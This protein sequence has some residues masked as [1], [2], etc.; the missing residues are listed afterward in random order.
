[1]KKLF[2]L[3]SL[4]LCAAAFA[5]PANPALKRRIEGDFPNAGNAPFV[6]YAVPAMSED[7]RLPEAYPAD[8]QAGAPVSIVLARDEYE[9]GSF[10]V[11][12]RRGGTRKNVQLSLGEFRNEKGDVFPAED[13]DLKVVKVWYQNKNAWFSYFGDTGRK[14]VPEL[15][16]HDET[17]F[18]VDEKKGA[19]YARVTTRDD[20]KT[21][22]EWLNPPCEFE[23]RGVLPWTS[24]LRFRSMREGFD[25]AKA[26]QPVLLEECRFKQ[27]FLTAHA[28]KDAKPGLYR[29]VVKVGD[30]GEIPV[31]IR[32]LD[33]ALP[34]PKAYQ[35]PSKDFLVSMYSDISQPIFEE[36]NGH[37]A[38]LARR[39]LVS[40]FKDMAAHNVSVHMIRGNTD[41]VAFDCIDAMREAGLRTDVLMGGAGPGQ[42]DTWEQSQERPSII[43]DELNRRYGHHNIY[44]GCG[45]EPPPSW[46]NGNRPLLALYQDAGIRFFLAASMPIYYLAGY[47]FDWHNAA[48]DASDPTFTKRWNALQNRNRSAWYAVQHV[49][50]ENPAFNRRQNGLTAYLTGYTSL[51]NY[52]FALDSYNDEVPQFRP[53]VYGYGCG[54]GVLDTLQWE[55]FREGVDDIRYATLMTD[56][57]RQA[58]KMQDTR[59]RYAGGQ[60]MQ[61]LATLDV[62]SFDQDW[63]RAEMIRYISEMLPYVSP[64][65]PESEF[66]PVS[67][68]ERA[69]SAKR[70]DERLEKALAKARKGFETA[71]NLQETNKVH[72][73]VADVYKWYARHEQAGE[74]LVQHGLVLDALPCFRYTKQEPRINELL[75]QALTDKSKPGY[76]PWRA[77]WA[78]LE[79]SPK[80]DAKVLATFEKAIFGD[81]KPTDTNGYRRVLGCIFHELG[82]PRR[83]LRNDKFA[84]F[85]SVFEKTRPFARRWNVA[86]PADVAFN[87][88]AAYAAQYD[89]R[90]AVESAKLGLKDEKAKPETLYRL[91]LAIALGSRPRQ[92]QAE[93]LAAIRTC[94]AEYAK[95]LPAKT[96]E[97]V[98]RIVGAFLP[99]EGF[100]DTIRALDEFR[101]SLLK[102]PNAKK[103]Y[104]VKFSDKAIDGVSDWN[105]VAAEETAYDRR[106]GGGLEFLETDVTT[107]NRGAVGTSKKEKMPDPT[108]KVVANRNGIHFFIVVKDPKA[109][110]IASGKMGVGSFEGYIAPG[111]NEPYV[112]LLMEP[113]RG[114][115]DTFNTTYNTFGR[116]WLADDTVARDY[117]IERTVDGENVVTYLF[118]SWREWSQKVPK[119]GSV[120]DFENLFWHRIGSFAWNG[121]ESIHGRS[122]WGELEFRLTDDQRR[123]ILKPLLARAYANFRTEQRCSHKDG[124][125]AHWKDAGVGDPAFYDAELKD[126]EKTL[127]SYGELLKPDISGSTI[128]FLA[129]VALPQWENVAFEVQ[130]RRT[131]WL[132]KLQTK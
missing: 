92:K 70:L 69:A 30:L 43:V 26:L 58:Q 46:F 19:N 98:L 90:H 16:L 82:T 68:A 1:M 23:E 85:T 128:D 18:R 102:A 61:F 127:A 131:R 126:L 106:Y 83:L 89:F 40:V 74:Y 39:Q 79:S 109:K 10:L 17:L 38:K 44:A 31:A 95:G 100:E 75:W 55:G 111:E 80:P 21:H 97:H 4:G 88:F 117:R 115:V 42:W 101:R 51:C 25:D 76:E 34:A 77:F 50:S 125:F 48:A 112:C 118:L 56:L 63:A 54:S 7:P 84:A 104:V 12:T 130:R 62:R 66:K 32:V 67:A 96:R 8:G 108:M 52:T 81:L 114:T 45:D 33:F 78:L 2:I 59:P 60:A 91:Q 57:A 47:L 124:V 22:E 64:S 13:L 110:E 113:D 123:E 94:D 87:A 107:G 73:K 121:T 103:R 93:A 71:K 119:D 99:S 14:L 120:W 132:E 36:K 28:K 6:H 3:L 65:K 24:A 86:I 15:L 72:G 9:P 122:T 5:A 37:D 27:F 116:R 29:G 129:N 11:W 49:G 20:G 105:R 53:M 35:D 41:P